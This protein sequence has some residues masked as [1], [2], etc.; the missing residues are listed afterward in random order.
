M[1]WPMAACQVEAQD[2]TG[3]DDRADSPTR[4]GSFRHAM[5]T[6]EAPLATSAAP[7]QPHSEI[8][9]T[10]GQPMPQHERLGHVEDL[11]G[12]DPDAQAHRD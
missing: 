3:A 8:R 10:H 11:N 9:L 2:L 5:T 6:E 12:P 4:S 7:I 1:D